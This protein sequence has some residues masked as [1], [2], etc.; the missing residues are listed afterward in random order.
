MGKPSKLATYA[1]SS[2]LMRIN[3]SWGKET[4][5]FNLYEELKISEDQITREA[6]EHPSSYAFLNM[7]LKKLIL[8][9]DASKSLMEKAWSREYAKYKQKIN[10][11]TNRPYND[12]LA[13]AK[14]DT[15]PVVKER[16]L[17]YYSYKNDANILEVAVKAFESRGSLIQ[18]IS[19]NVRNENK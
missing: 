10:P 4:F 17:E 6:K 8:Q 9:V 7:L 1:E 11:D 16:R 13:K 2:S 3:V 18:T 15:S 19:A 5:K 12:D 14:A